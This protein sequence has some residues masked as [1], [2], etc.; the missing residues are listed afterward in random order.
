MTTVNAATM[1]T[2]TIISGLD[3]SDGLMDSFNSAEITRLSVGGADNDRIQSNGNWPVSGAYDESKYI[4]FVFNPNL[5]NGAVIDSINLNHEYY[6]TVKLT[7]AKVEIWD[8]LNFVDYPINLTKS[9]G[10]ANEIS[11]TIDI[12]KTIDTVEKLNAIKVRFLAY[13]N[14]PGVSVKTSHDSINLMVLYTTAQ[15]LLSLEVSPSINKEVMINLDT[16]IIS[17]LEIPIIQGPV[18]VYPQSEIIPESNIL[19]EEIIAP[20]VLKKIEEEVRTE[21]KTP[22]L[23]ILPQG[24][25]PEFLPEIIENIPSSTNTSDPN[26]DI[27]VELEPTKDESIILLDPVITTDLENPDIVKQ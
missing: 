13:R 15:T 12:I 1:S 7:S 4:E 3:N 5:D 6:E 11:E 8:G 25:I 14:N 26:V 19:S 9:T 2:Y 23:E 24:I 10:T 21:E 20:E 22:E 17:P 18:P 27:V 16:E